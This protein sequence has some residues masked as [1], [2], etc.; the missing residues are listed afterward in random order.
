M[1]KRRF[2]L[3]AVAP[4]DFELTLEVTPPA[5]PF[6]YESSALRRA[7]RLESGELV[8]VEVRA[9]GTTE[10]PL[11]EVVAHG[12][13]SEKGRDQIEREL[14]RFL[15]L[16]DD[17]SG[18]IELMRGYER[19]A[20][21]VEAFEG[22]RPWTEM[23]PFEG[24]V[25]AVIFQQISIWAAFSIIRSLVQR[26]GPKVKADGKVFYEFPD[27]RKLASVRGSTLRACKLS[28]N[29]AKYVRSLAKEFLKGDL[30]FE[31]LAA[32]PSSA[33]IE[34]LKKLKG[35]GNWTAEMFM[36]MGL[37]RWD[38]IPADDL[39]LR[40]AVG[41]FCLGRGR[42]TPE[43]VREV[44]EGWEKYKWPITYYLLV[45]SERK[46]RLRSA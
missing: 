10:K 26:L 40:R 5:Y 11:L 8:P 45:A 21:I 1:K 15:C 39:G 41:E 16:K 6:V 30:N 28:R 22:V 20:P 4:F 18:A 12:D 13:L 34:E 27:A 32:M 3:E 35:V 36:A 31:A 9:I 19:L 23:R 17:L 44:A 24:L 46:E 42:A 37:K 14:S 33:A 25:C 2:T 29:K 43:E 7:F 38:V